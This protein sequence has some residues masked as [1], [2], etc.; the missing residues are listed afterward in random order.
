MAG[1]GGIAN[2]SNANITLSLV[3]NNT[4]PGATGGGFSITAP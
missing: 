1:A 3:N 4:A 2:G